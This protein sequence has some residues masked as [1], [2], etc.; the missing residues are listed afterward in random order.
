M[1]DRKG[2]PLER[3][4]YVRVFWYDIGSRAAL[5]RILSV[6][7][8]FSGKYAGRQTF[9]IL[10]GRRNVTGA[11]N[12]YEPVLVERWARGVEWIDPFIVRAA[13]FGVWIP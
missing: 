4:D 12:V 13:A 10:V 7:T 1:G 2:H 8:E 6:V 3:G 9:T 5:G 11:Q